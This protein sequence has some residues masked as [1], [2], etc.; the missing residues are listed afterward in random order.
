MTEPPP[1]E[2]PHIAEIDGYTGKSSG[3]PPGSTS[4][5]RRLERVRLAA[6]VM[7][8]LDEARVVFPL[9]Q[10]GPPPRFS[11]PTLALPPESGWRGILS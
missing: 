8:L 1:V 5:G 6:E 7:K 3:G 9:P 2:V 4:I 11:P 10:P